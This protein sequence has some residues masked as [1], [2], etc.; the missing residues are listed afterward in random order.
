MEIIIMSEFDYILRAV[1]EYQVTRNVPEDSFWNIIRHVED[2]DEFLTAM[3]A[4]SHLME[5]VENYNI[6]KERYEQ[7][8]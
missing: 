4:Q 1:A 5:L 6:M 7:S 3:Q 8:D 2:G